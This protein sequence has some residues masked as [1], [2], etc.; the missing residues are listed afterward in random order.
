MK[1]K[2]IGL[3]CEEGLNNVIKAGI[4]LGT[5]RSVMCPMLLTLMMTSV[6]K[7]STEPVHLIAH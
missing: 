3:I 2:S 7:T 6:C 4:S 1:I 5:I